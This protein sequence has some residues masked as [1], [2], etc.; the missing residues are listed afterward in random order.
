MEH[1]HPCPLYS[2][3]QQLPYPNGRAHLVPY[4]T[5]MTCRGL[6]IPYKHHGANN[7]KD[8]Q[9]CQGCIP[10]EFFGPTTNSRNKMLHCTFLKQNLNSF[11]HR[12]HKVTSPRI[13]LFLLVTPILFIGSHMVMFNTIPSI[14][15][16]RLVLLSS[17]KFGGLMSLHSA[18]LSSLHTPE[19][20]GH[21]NTCLSNN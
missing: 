1:S 3:A 19:Y 10:N 11:P 5:N 8:L 4:P 17:T 7:C 20:L 6:T 15:K 2:R 16:A 12:T 18:C 9:N 13:S 14:D 21:F